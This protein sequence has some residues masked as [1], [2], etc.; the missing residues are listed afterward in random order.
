MKVLI[1]DCWTRKSLSAV[2]SLGEE[3][4]EVHATSH[5]RLSA[6]LYSKYTKK[7]TIVPN[8]KTD[9]HEYKKAIIQ[10]LQQE[11]FDVILP[12][13]ETSIEAFYEIL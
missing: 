10:L 7:Y 3:G 4:V 8:P 12:F 13:E 9:K 11:K 5:T 1:T 6:A 2:R